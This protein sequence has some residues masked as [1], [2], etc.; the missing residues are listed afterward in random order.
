MNMILKDNKILKEADFVNEK[1]LQTY[2][3]KNI[4]SILGLKLIA[5]EFAVGSFRIDTL[6][7]DDESK[8]FKIVEYKNVKNHS[9]VDQGYTYLKLMLERKADFVLHYNLKTNSNISINDIDWSQSRIIFVSP[10]FTP[11]Q[12]NAADFKNIPVDLYRATK[13]EDGIVNMDLIQKTSNVKIEEVKMDIKTDPVS[14]EIKVYAE[15]DHLARG[16]KSLKIVYET[17]KEKI[18]ELDDIDID[19]KKT[20]IA[21]K[22]SKNIIDVEFFKSFIQLTLNMK[23]GTLND[24]QSI[25]SCYV[26]DDGKTIGHHGNGDYYISIKH[27]DE[28]DQLI[29]LIKQSIEA[30]KK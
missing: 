24:P 1:E 19:V 4:E 29:P 6:A 26:L 9:L 16:I 15:E 14:K 11:Y 7:F 23:K 5:T 8:S 21:F 20:Y 30:N 25:M 12:L 17:L 2:F 18:L 13:Y 27:V 3:E 22:G 10:V 28:V